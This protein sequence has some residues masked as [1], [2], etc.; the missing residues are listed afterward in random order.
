MIED[1]DYMR[2]PE[3]R[4]PW[5][6]GF[7]WSWTVVLLLLNAAFFVIEWIALLNPHNG[8]FIQKYL[9]LSLEGLRH[10]CVWQLLTFQFLHA[11]LWHLLFNCLT[12]FFFGRPVEMV[13]GRH[14][15]LALYLISGIIGGVV[16][17]LFALALPDFFGGSVVGASAGAAGL[18]AAFAVLN[19][20]ERFTLLIYFFPVNMRGRTL[21]WVSV[22]LAVIG[23]L[24]PK[25]SIANAAHLG[26]ILA[27]FVYVR[28]LLQGRPSQ[29]EFPVR[30]S[31]PR[32]LA[33]RLKENKIWRAKAVPPAEE[34]SAEEFLQ[35]EVDPILDKI[36]AQGIQSLT[37]RE[38]ETL[39]RARAKMAKR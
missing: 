38:R 33:A 27:G 5:F 4:D 14:R 15:F 37:A 10:G 35:K 2:Q 16:Q 23:I 19:W 36:S 1:R 34:Q 31:A 39:E 13:L 22:A 7:R 6:H 17:M 30:R 21:F 24:T 32:E 25:S 8:F 29:S 28:W 20:Q 12:I 11:G 18:V 26:G 3:Y 9:A